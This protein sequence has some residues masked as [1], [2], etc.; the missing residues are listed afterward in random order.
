[1]RSPDSNDY[2]KLAHQMK[3]LQATEHLPLII[4]NDG[5]GTRIYIDGAH[6][7]H[8]D[9]KG[10]AGVW[11]TEGTGTIYAASTKNKLNVVSSTEA[12]I[13]SVG[14]KL[15][16]HIW[17]RK[18]RIAQENKEEKPDILYQD[19]ES[20]ILMENNGRISVGKGSKHIDIRYFFVTDRVKRKEI[21]IK[22]CPTTE[23]V[24]DFFTKPLQ[25]CTFHKL[26]NV[27]LGIKDS[28]MER[29]KGYWMNMLKTFG[30]TTSAI[31]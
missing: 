7:V 20:A 22:H 9:M 14:E 27:V 29:Y 4:R 30:L 25:G 26:R 1:M 10:H 31:T 2:K 11:V 12:E 16:K 3:Y 19:N 21:Q 18:Y 28:M 8:G 17:Y 13:V 24:A 15:P 5:E 6:A 23:M